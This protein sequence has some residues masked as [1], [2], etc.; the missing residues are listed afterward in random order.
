[1]DPYVSLRLDSQFLDQSS[2]LGDIKFNPVK[3]TES[4]G[5]ARLL[6]KTA[7]SEA[8][9]RLGFGFRQTLASSIV[10][11]TLEK[12]SFTTNDGGL[13]WQTSVTQPILEKKVLYRG[14]LLVFQPVFYSKSSA[15][16]DFD[17][18]ALA[19]NPG[20]E[21]VADF[22][23]TPEVNFQNTFTAAITKSLSVGLEAVLVY[24]KFNSAAN[25]DP[26]RPIADQIPEIDRNVRK[27]GQFK[28][29]LAVG[30]TYRLF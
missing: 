30:F 14:Q 16:E 6:R 4:A 15:L 5:I 22:W 17:A 3:L 24:D 19:A 13:E 7:D 18:L 1:V 12:E 21:S 27:A 25:V 11:S 2:P 29:V 9:T 8:I 28:E 26:S 20:R 10:P 23:K